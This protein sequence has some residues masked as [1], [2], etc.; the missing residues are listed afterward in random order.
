MVRPG[1]EGTQSFELIVFNFA[2]DDAWYRY[3]VTAAF[4]C[5]DFSTTHLF[6]GWSSH[7]IVT[8]AF[9]LFGYHFKLGSVCSNKSR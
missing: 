4:G 1:K 8:A 2:M 7:N 9:T 3:I 6:F 5:N